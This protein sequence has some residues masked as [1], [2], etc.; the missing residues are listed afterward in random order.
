MALFLPSIAIIISVI[1]WLVRQ[2][3]SVK[4]LRHMIEPLICDVDKLKIDVA[5]CES[6]IDIV[7]SLVSTDVKMKRSDIWETHS[8]PVLKKGVQINVPTDLHEYVKG[9]SCNGNIMVNSRV[10]LSM[11]KSFG[12]ERLED[13]AVKRDMTV[14]EY[15]SYVIDSGR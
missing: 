1:V 9:E 10:I 8:M 14:I 5:K 12:I 7:L 3:Q 15:I 2:N 11:V 13:D 6:Y 4:S